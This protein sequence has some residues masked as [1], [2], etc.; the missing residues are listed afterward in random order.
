MRAGLGKSIDNSPSNSRRPVSDFTV[1]RTVE[2]GILE[3]EVIYLLSDRV[4]GVFIGY[5]EP[6][7]FQKGHH[8]IVDFDFGDVIWKEFFRVEPPT[9]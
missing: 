9:G 4:T 1:K 3:I 8:P 7:R 5:V 6:I 2:I